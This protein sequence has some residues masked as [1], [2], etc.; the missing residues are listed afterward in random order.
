MPP[1][2]LREFRDRLLDLKPVSSP[3]GQQLLNLKLPTLTEPEATVLLTQA[4][5]GWLQMGI[6][7]AAEQDRGFSAMAANADAVPPLELS[8]DAAV[9]GETFRESWVSDLADASLVA[10]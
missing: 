3:E 4:V 9:V 5:L 7:R 8:R 6:E 10:L 2:C 1:R